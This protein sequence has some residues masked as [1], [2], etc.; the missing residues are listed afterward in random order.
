MCQ[1]QSTTIVLFMNILKRCFINFPPG[2]STQGKYTTDYGSQ[3]RWWKDLDAT[4]NEVDPKKLVEIHQDKANSFLQIFPQMTIRFQRT[5][6]RQLTASCG[7]FR[8]R[9]TDACRRS[10]NPQLPDNLT[11]ESSERWVAHRRWVAQRIPHTEEEARNLDSHTYKVYVK[12]ETNCMVDNHQ[13]T[14]T[15]G[16]LEPSHANPNINYELHKLLEEKYSYLSK[17][18]VKAVR[19]KRHDSLGHGSKLFDSN[20]G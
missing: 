14:M 18:F 20:S 16:W 8:R 9:L 3:I 6:H 17:N 19:G 5:F 13:Q 1:K 7:G 4:Y 10:F 15:C 12:I 2:S 11:E